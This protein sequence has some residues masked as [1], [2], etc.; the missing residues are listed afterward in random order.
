[1]RQPLIPPMVT[2][3]IQSA[4]CSFEDAEFSHIA[5]CP[6]CGGP[7]QGYDTREKRYVVI[8]EGEKKRTITVKVKRF[9]CRHCHTLCNADEPFYPNTRIGSLVIDLYFTL[10][11]TMPASRAGR[12][13]NAMGFVV[14]RTT[15]RNYYRPDYPEIPAA[16]IFGM[17]LPLSIISLSTLAAR[18]SKNN[19]KYSDEMLAVSGYPSTYR[20]AERRSGRIT[21]NKKRLQIGSPMA[22]SEGV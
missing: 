11:S 20:A 13:I 17:R 2:D 5:A 10:S 3:I 12:I 22:S 8:N 14:D 16:D 21:D 18:E 9:L 1:M 4:I 19:R 6:V 7:V 15:W